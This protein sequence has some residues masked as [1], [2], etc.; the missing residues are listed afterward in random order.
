MAKRKRQSDNSGTGYEGLDGD[1]SIV[2]LFLCGRGVTLTHHPLLVPWSRKG[3]AIPLLPLWAVRHLQSLSACTRV[4]FTFFVPTLS[5]TLALDGGGWSTRRPG[6]LTHRKETRYQLHRRLSGSYGRFGRVRK[7][8]LPAG[9]D[10]RNLQSVTLS[11]YRQHCP[12]PQTLRC[13]YALKDGECRQ[14]TE[15]NGRL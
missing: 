1:Y 11:L 13:K 9:F 3:R 2:L 15:K 6:G 8:S 5:L 7:I 4:H 12:D 10:P 14:W